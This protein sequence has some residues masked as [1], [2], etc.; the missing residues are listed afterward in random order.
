MLT[1]G[2]LQPLVTFRICRNRL[3]IYRHTLVTL[4]VTFTVWKLISSIR[5]SHALQVQSIERLGRAL[6]ESMLLVVAAAA[7]W[8]MMERL[9]LTT[10]KRVIRKPGSSHRRLWSVKAAQQE[11]SMPEPLFRSWLNSLNSI[12]RWFL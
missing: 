12:T 11:P 10:A 3:Q 7:M 5:N 1:L 6:M 2:R 8:L 4:T 9:L